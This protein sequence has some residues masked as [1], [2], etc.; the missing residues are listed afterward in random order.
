MPVQLQVQSLIQCS[1]HPCTQ[2]QRQQEEEVLQ[3]EAAA[4]KVMVK[5]DIQAHR[6][7]EEEQDQ[8]EEDHLPQE[9]AKEE[10][11]CRG[12]PNHSHQVVIERCSAKRAPTR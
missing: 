3:E 7:Q 8:E 9:E 11:R 6:R 12:E 10:A 5:V 2:G 1:G 4:V